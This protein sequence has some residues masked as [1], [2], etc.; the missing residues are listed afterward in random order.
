MKY[1]L[2]L[3][4]T[5]PARSRNYEMSSRA[6]AA[7]LGIEFQDQMDFCCCGFPIKASDE[8]AATL[9]AARNLA[10]A[11]EMNLEI[12]TLCS[13]C[14]A[15]LAEVAHKL[16]YDEGFRE[17]INKDLAAIGRQVKGTAR[18]RHFARI[19]LEDIGVEN[20]HRSVTVDLKG[21]P[22]AVHYGC[23]YLKPSYIYEGGEDPEA[24][25]S[26]DALI[27]AAGAKSISY[28]RKKFCCGGSVLVADEKT[29]LGMAKEKLDQVQ[30]AGGRSMVVVCPF[31]SVMYD[32]NQKSI[33]SAFNV[34]YQIPVLYLPQVL[35]LAMGMDRKTLGLNMNVVKTRKITEDILGTE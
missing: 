29:A 10:L 22:V 2:F 5:I 21:F 26:L 20:I 6:V 1:A 4:C 35:G 18:V 15:M 16:R 13:A 24:A 12:C 7:K 28:I 17:E 3:G 33:E 31:C 34:S 30:A 8:H 9:L 32:D 27:A 23:H 19:L 14:T 11:E 25:R